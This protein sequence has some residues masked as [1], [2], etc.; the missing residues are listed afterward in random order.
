MEWWHVDCC[1][2]RCETKYAGRATQRKCSEIWTKIRAA[3]VSFRSV[4][5]VAESRLAIGHFNRPLADDECRTLRSA[6]ERSRFFPASRISRCS[7]K[8]VSFVTPPVDV[9]AT[10]HSID[11]L[12]ATPGSPRPRDAPQP[13]R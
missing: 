7:E 9:D 13:M 10:W 11:A 12:L 8:Q 4:F 6:W 3:K 5:P 2:Y 1:F